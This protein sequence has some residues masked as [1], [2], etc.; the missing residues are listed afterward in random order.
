MLEKTKQSGTTVDP[1]QVSTCRRCNLRASM[2]KRMNLLRGGALEQGLLRSPLT[3]AARLR[4]R[5]LTRLRGWET[6][7]VRFHFIPKATRAWLSVSPK[8]L[9]SN[10]LSPYQRNGSNPFFS[11]SFVLFTKVLILIFCP[12]QSKFYPHWL[13]FLMLWTQRLTML[14]AFW[15]ICQ[16]KT[17]F[18]PLKNKSINK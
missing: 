14:R 4:I 1:P 6:P 8:R 11:A 5:P 15:C 7:G 2:F 18:T 10:R 13:F 12:I 17:I 9:L 3:Q 16:Q